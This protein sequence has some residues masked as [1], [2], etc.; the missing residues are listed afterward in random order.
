MAAVGIAPH[1]DPDAVRW[2]AIRHAEE[3][4]HIV[5]T[6]VR[7][8]GATVWAWNERLKAQAAARD[9]EERYGLYKV[10]PSDRTSHRRPGAAERNKSE[11]QGLS[12]IPRDRL[13]HE[14]RG[15]AA[16]AVSEAE[17]FA[18]L[19]A[20]G[21][22]VRLRHSN[23]D[24]DEVTGYAVGLPG[25]HTAT[26]DTVWYSG[27]RL[28]PDLTLPRLRGRWPDV[29][30][31]P[32]G[33]RRRTMPA[34]R[35]ADAFLRAASALRHATEK[36]PIDEATEDPSALIQSVGDILTLTARAFEGRNGGPLTEAAEAF[37]RAVREPYRH[38]TRRSRPADD[39]RSLSRLIAVAGRITGDR[40]TAAA[41]HLVLQLSRFADSL[42]DLREAQQRLHQARTARQTAQQLRTIATTGTALSPADERAPLQVPDPGASARRTHVT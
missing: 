3:H 14:V 12:V 7:Q 36:L 32:S 16:A 2:V 6:L 17:F 30:G 21:V 20:A 26:G 19:R 40:D 31:P 22:L 29:T 24:P 38:R 9:L 23:A 27:G 18:A 35:R 10:G 15:A 11:R 42:A 5:A 4:I 34:G 25:H 28:A 13:R 1:N 39:L 8:D 33:I 37:D 41:L